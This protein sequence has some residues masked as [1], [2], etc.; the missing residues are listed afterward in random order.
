M[1][2][3]PAVPNLWTLLQIWEPLEYPS[4]V[5]QFLCSSNGEK[6]EENAKNICRKRIYVILR[7]VSC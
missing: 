1:K 6:S 5:S 4:F 7:M 2:T 3:Q